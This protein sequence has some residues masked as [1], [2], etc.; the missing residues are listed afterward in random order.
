MAA[1]R[2]FEVA[3]PDL[4]RAWLLPGAALLMGM[5]GITLG[6]REQPH[7]LWLLGV[8]AAATA[9][10]HLSLSRRAVTLT[11]DL[12]HVSAGINDLR[13]RTAEI[14]LD[15]AAV[16]D[17]E[18]TPALRPLV[19]TFGTSMPGY[20]AGHFRLRDRGPAFLL[21]TG[22]RKALLLPLRNG[23]RILAS[24]RQ[25]EQLLQ[26]LRDVAPGAPRR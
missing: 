11:G 6:A 1:T 23:K 3:P 21:L 19:K 22:T 14:D 26:A 17:L 18:A 10:I 8:L 9:L 5:L 25:P 16:V 2:S 20:Q 24:V 15:A 12:L 7:V 13:A 4:R